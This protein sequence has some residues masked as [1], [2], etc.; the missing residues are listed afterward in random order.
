MEKQVL[1]TQ[2]Q[3]EKQLRKLD[4]NEQQLKDGKQQVL[5]NYAIGRLDR[6]TYLEKCLWYDNEV[7]KLKLEK[8]EFIKRIPTLHK[9]DVV[10]M[11]VRIFC[12][13]AR[14]RFEKCDN[15]DTKRRFLLDFIEQIIYDHGKITVKGSIP[16]LPQ[17]QAHN[18]S[19]QI[20][21]TSKIGFKITS[22]ICGTASAS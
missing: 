17:P 21:E 9:K 13:T 22:E 12:D 16:L 2:L 4:R 18:N 6:N 19:N 3:T 1:L 20:S 10:D 14:A 5:D 7:N 8:A 15:F 11:S